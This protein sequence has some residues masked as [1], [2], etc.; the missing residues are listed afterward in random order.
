MYAIRSYYD[1]HHPLG[2]V[3]KAAL[4]VNL[5]QGRD[6][7]AG[8]VRVWRCTDAGKALAA[9][10]LDRAPL[11]RRVLA[12]LS[13]APD[14]CDAAALTR[15]VHGWRSAMRSLVAK[16]WA[17]VEQRAAAAAEPEH[18]KVISGPRLT[19]AQQSAVTAIT[20]ALRNNFV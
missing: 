7:D 18:A 20:D 9:S 10:T 15:A 3:L 1:Y 8:A 16:G 5:R 12:A 11:Q 13:E 19:T 6:L 2:E 14:G 17:Q 4:P